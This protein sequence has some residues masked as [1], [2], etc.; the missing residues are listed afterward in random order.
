M[1][2]ARMIQPT[3]QHTCANVKRDG[4]AIVIQV[5]ID[6]L[7][8]FESMCLLHLLHPEANLLLS[9]ESK[10]IHFLTFKN[11]EDPCLQ[12]PC[13]FGQCSVDAK[14]K[15]ACTCTNGYGGKEC[16]ESI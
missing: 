15:A 5:K 7:H 1:A 16:D 10:I 11:K 12:S 8:T 4:W 9:V 14:L 13:K 6:R 2:T 3:R